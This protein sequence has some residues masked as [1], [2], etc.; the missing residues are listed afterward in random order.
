MTEREAV[1]IRLS[2][3]TQFAIKIYVGGVNAVSGEPAVE[4]TATR[5]RRQKRK[6]DGGSLQD[7]VV[8]PQQL[9]VD[10]I[11]TADGTV[12]QFVAVQ[13][14]QGFSVE[15]QITGEEVTAGL[16]FEVTGRQRTWAD[17]IYVE[18]PKEQKTSM[19]VDLSRR[20]GDR[21]GRVDQTN[22]PS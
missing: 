18:Y 3:R 13:S 10:G 4:A 16:Q 5:L 11:T 20:D 22:H 19:T 15:A 1:W 9:W 6:S 8:T 14:G 17:L 21:S 12:R 2:S 7:Y